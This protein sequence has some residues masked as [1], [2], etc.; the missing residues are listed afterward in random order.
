MANNKDITQAKDLNKD[1]NLV[2]SAEFLSL[3]FEDL[4]SIPVYASQLSKDLSLALNAL[5]A[6][7]DREAYDFFLEMGYYA[8]S[9]IPVDRSL[10][11][12]YKGADNSIL[13]PEHTHALLT[14]DLEPSLLCYSEFA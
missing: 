10:E 8:L 11:P 13:Q 4:F 7:T 1:L 5:E 9:T 14:H 6:Q 3:S 12:A 2:P